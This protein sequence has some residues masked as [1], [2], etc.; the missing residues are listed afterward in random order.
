MQRQ[1]GR[2]GPDSAGRWAQLEPGVNMG[3]KVKKVD[4]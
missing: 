4:R 2:R 3:D 1:G